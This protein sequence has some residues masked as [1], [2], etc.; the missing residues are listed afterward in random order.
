MILQ[1]LG[2]KNG[3]FQQ[4][5]P[6]A[7]DSNDPPHLFCI[8]GVVGHRSISISRVISIVYCS[9][10]YLYEIVYFQGTKMVFFCSRCLLHETAMIHHIYFVFQVLQ[11]IETSVSRVISIVYCSIAYL[12][13]IVCFEG[14]KMV[15]FSIRC[16]LHETAKIHHIYFVFQVL[17]QELLALCTAR[18]RILMRQSVFRAKKWCVLVV[19]AHCTRQQ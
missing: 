10:A 6:T 8:P 3:L 4:Q 16:L 19:D 11:V 9:I 12:Y 17:Y 15:C 7:R 18:L 1:L 2:P 5:M 13:E 14:Q